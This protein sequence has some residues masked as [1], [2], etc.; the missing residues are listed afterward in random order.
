MFLTSLARSK[1]LA[2]SLTCLIL[3]EFLSSVPCAHAYLYLLIFHLLRSGFMVQ[4]AHLLAAFPFGE[5]Q[6]SCA[7][8]VVCS[9]THGTGNR[10]LV[11]SGSGPGRRKAL[12][13]PRQTCSSLPAWSRAWRRTHSTVRSSL[14]GLLFLDLVRLGSATVTCVGAGFML[15]FQG[16]W[17]I[18][19]LWGGSWVFPPTLT[20]KGCSSLAAPFFSRALYSTSTR[21]GKQ[22]HFGEIKDLELVLCYQALFFFF[23][24]S[25][26]TFIYF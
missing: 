7:C 1:H 20:F 16:L 5:K 22:E 23:F 10:R 3:P 6:A 15:L 11:A 17:Q 8:C 12:R 26:N 4:K 2:A 13:A 9:C 21:H 25:L 18:L 19:Q 24:F 14:W